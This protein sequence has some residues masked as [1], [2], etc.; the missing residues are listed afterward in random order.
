MSFT[1]SKALETDIFS[2]C[3]LL[4]GQVGLQNEIRWVNILEILDDLSHIEP[5]EFL[6]TTAH[7]FNYHDNA[8]QR[9]MIELFASNKLAAIA[10]QTGHYIKEIPSTFVRFSEEYHIPLIEIP[11]E[12]SFKSL[13]RTLLS[14]LM[15][16]DQTQGTT[17]ALVENHLLLESQLLEMKKL[18]LVLQDSE[19]PEDLHEKFVKHGIKP[20]EPI[21][22]LEIAIERCEEEQLKKVNQAQASL[23]SQVEKAA[24][25]ILMQRHIDFLLGTSDKNL[26][27]L[28]QS[29]QLSG[30]TRDK[31]ASNV[32]SLTNQLFNELSLLF[33][34]CTISIGA[35][36]FRSSISEFKIA[37]HE[38]ERTLQAV[39]LGLLD[40]SGF[41]S[42]KDLGFYRLIMDIENIETLKDIYHETIAPLYDYDHDCKGNLVETVK[43]FLKHFNIRKAAEA[44]FVHRHTMKY[45]LNQIESLTGHNP[46]DPSDAMQLNI[47]LHICCYLKTLDLLD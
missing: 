32:I 15:N 14:E 34:G 12:V 21:Q 20:R 44:M 6:I 13:T 40:N 5:G 8:K 42:Y 10:I 37:R 38:A 46:L 19:N 33:P 28:I 22:V 7:G 29:N 18:W 23:S 1:V 36:T 39:R 45:R 9:N 27:L 2:K 11:S 41:I 30:I 47:G 26:T 43:I 25:Q 17:N 16:Y 3:N 31:D 24:A 4:T 35:S